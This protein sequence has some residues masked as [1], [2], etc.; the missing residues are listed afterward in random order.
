MRLGQTAVRRVDLCIPFKSL[1]S[2]FVGAAGLGRDRCR[3]LPP[4]RV[5]FAPPSHL[6]G[7]C[8]ADR[9][10]PMRHAPWSNSGASRIYFAVPKSL[11]KNRLFISCRLRLLFNVIDKKGRG[12]IKLVLTI[13]TLYLTSEPARNF[14][15][16]SCSPVPEVRP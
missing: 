8:G 6:R 16:V 11:S 13:T 15:V 2:H 1:Y 4:L 9:Y 12:I 7:V 3:R 10:E 14:M 5:D